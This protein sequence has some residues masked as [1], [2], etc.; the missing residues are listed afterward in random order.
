MKK[1][2]VLSLVVS[3]VMIFSL[4]GFGCKKAE[5]PAEAPKQSEQAQAPAAVPQSGALEYGFED[6]TGGW[7]PNGK[8]VKIEQVTNQ[9]HGGNSSLKISG[10]AGS[11]LWNFA[12]SPKIN[13]EAGKKYK[14][15]G[16]MFVE[17]WDKADFPPLL[18]YGVYQDNK[19]VSN[20]FTEKYNLKK[21]GEW[22]R[23]LTVFE[24]PQ[25]GSISGFVALE[26]GTQDPINAS[27]YLDDIK[28]EPSK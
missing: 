14:L 13:L 24:T 28:I 15:T 18:K 26:K 5:Q 3:G 11:G 10:V 9:K 22:Q 7:N 4:A 23:I 27:V 17:S 19:W 6:G 20:A 2:Q 25:G 21:K 16:W 1:Y 8:T 12:A